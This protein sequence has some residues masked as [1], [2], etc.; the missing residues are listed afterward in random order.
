MYTFDIYVSIVW[1]S[2]TRVR[3]QQVN[4]AYTTEIDDQHFND[5]GYGGTFRSP[6][7]PS[8]SRRQ[9]QVASTSWLC[10]WN[11]TTDLY[12]ILEHVITNFR[13]RGRHQR[14]F[15]MNLFV[16]RSAASISSV[17]DTIMQLY[18]DLPYCFKEVP[19]VTCDP[20]R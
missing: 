9:I 8:P 15:P 4:V 12:R 2:V 13:D 11:F 16:D 14:S 6:V 3:E 7:Q 20:A 17:R 18:A 1:D 5:Q 10:G 19:Q